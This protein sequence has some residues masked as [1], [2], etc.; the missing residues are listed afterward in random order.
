MTSG[1]AVLLPR[2]F[3]IHPDSL[4][5]LGK[6]DDRIKQEKIP[7][8]FPPISGWFKALVLVIICVLHYDY[9][10]ETTKLNILER[11]VFSFLE[12]ETLKEVVQNRRNR[13][14]FTFQF[15]MIR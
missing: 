13:Q 14:N 3:C 9:F 11:S 5:S 6:I 10:G 7:L 15:R 8:G 2:W 12:D 4:S 1:W